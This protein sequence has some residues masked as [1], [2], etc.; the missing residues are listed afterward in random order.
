MLCHSAPTSVPLAASSSGVTSFR[1]CTHVFSHALIGAMSNSTSWLFSAP[2]SWEDASTASVRAPGCQLFLLV[3]QGFCVTFVGSPCRKLMRRSRTYCHLRRW[4]Y[5]MLQLMLTCSQ[6]TRPGKH[7]PNQ[8]RSLSKRFFF[9][10]NA[11]TRSQWLLCSTGVLRRLSD[12]VLLQLSGQ[13]CFR[14]SELLDAGR[15]PGFPAGPSAIRA[16]LSLKPE[17][18]TLLRSKA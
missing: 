12:A 4:I 13:F 6:P 1:V 5:S 9:F 18:Q 15:T 14:R 10:F 8:K 2:L 7:Q 17:P 16:V 11:G 3:F